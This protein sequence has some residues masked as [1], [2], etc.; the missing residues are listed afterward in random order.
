MANSDAGQP[1]YVGKR[2][3]YDGNRCTV[4]YVGPV[5]GT[6][7]KWYG[8]EWDDDCPKGKHDGTL[9]GTRYFYCTCNTSPTHFP[10]SYYVITL[11]S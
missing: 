2:L 4:R 5:E 10:L 6:D 11:I 9:N 1:V 7:G 3:S 8:V